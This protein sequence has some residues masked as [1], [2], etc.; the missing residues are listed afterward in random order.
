MTTVGLAGETFPFNGWTFKWFVWFIKT[1]CINNWTWNSM[2]RKKTFSRLWAVEP[3]N[4]FRKQIFPKEF[5]FIFQHC[6]TF[7]RRRYFHHRV[8]PSIFWWIATQLVK[9]LKGSPLVHQFGPTFGFFGYCRRQ[10]FDTLKSFRYFLSLRYSANLGRPRLV[11]LVEQ[12]KCWIQTWR[13]HDF[14][15]STFYAKESRLG[16]Y[17][18]SNFW[19]NRWID[20]CTQ[21]CVSCFLC[22]FLYCIGIV[23]KYHHT[24]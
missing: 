13:M 9:N 15:A 10:Y 18:S 7:F 23:Y 14:D 1:A 20:S 21:N 11:F 12:I 17:A 5:P 3:T 6:E 19:L 22:I 24:R 8:P 4:F 16:V 2:F